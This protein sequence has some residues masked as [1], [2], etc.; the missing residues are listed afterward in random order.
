MAVYI[1]VTY[2]FI[3]MADV[4]E[5]CLGLSWRNFLISA[6]IIP[7]LIIQKGSFNNSMNDHS[8]ISVS[9]YIFKN[10]FYL[11]YGFL[12]SYS[13]AVVFQNELVF[14]S[15]MDIGVKNNF[16]RPYPI[17]P[18]DLLDS[19]QAIL[20]FLQILFGSFLLVANI[21]WEAKPALG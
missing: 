4:L 9:I 19:N 18:L 21:R 11:G 17:S 2:T 6:S 10:M 13:L 12:V 20:V 15:P 8:A 1:A 7:I 14:Q 16:L 5:I 3:E